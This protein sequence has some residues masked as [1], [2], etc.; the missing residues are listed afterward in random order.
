VDPSISENDHF[1]IV[2]MDMLNDRLDATYKERQANIP[3]V[4]SILDEEIAEFEKWMN[5]QRLVP[6]I[7]ALTRRLDEIRTDELAK[8]RHKFS[9]DD[10]LIADQLTRRIV[11][12]ILAYSIDHLK[13]DHERP[14]DI[15]KMV[16]SLFK[17]EP[18]A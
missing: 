10:A 3:Q 4:E 1:L 15:T 12:K 8:Y 9:A 7:R 2:N 5:E 14:E 16:Q 11:N 6:T 17:I 18:D 13:E